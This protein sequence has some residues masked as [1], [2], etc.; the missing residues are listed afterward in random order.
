[1]VMD[2]SPTEYEISSSSSSLDRLSEEEIE[3]CCFLEA[4]DNKVMGLDRRF[5][6][7]MRMLEARR[8]RVSVF[9]LLLSSFSSQSSLPKDL[10]SGI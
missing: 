10:S 7:I 1:M 2:S 9:S 6:S 5:W 8:F 3:L 4:S